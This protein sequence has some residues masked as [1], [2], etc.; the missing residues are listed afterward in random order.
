[1]I[2]YYDKFVEL[3]TNKQI[4]KQTRWMHQWWKMKWFYKLKSRWSINEIIEIN[5]K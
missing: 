1:M 3:I 5:I 4:N 2:D